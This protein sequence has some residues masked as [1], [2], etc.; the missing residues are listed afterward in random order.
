MS[1]DYEKR[2]ADW[3][4]QMRDTMLARRIVTMRGILD[5]ALAGRIA[6]EL[7]TLDASGDELITLY[8]DSSGGTL[9]AAF[10]VID[11]IDLLGVPIH[12]V[13]IG[14]AE[15]PAAA[16]VAAC[17]RRKV[18]PHATFRLCEPI[19][20]ATGHASDMKR[21]AEQQRD[22]LGKFVSLLNEITS[23][24]IEHI[25]ADVAAGRYLSAEEAVEYGLVDE[26]WSPKKRQADPENR[27]QFGF[28][29]PEKPHLRAY[30]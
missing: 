7:M 12:S 10:T 23:R 22:Q 5:E 30:E 14:R 20:Q 9:E 25:E 27:P 19:S 8:I 24:P 11:V 29:P 17:D 1:D 13:C 26:V 3:E 2:Q 4:L 16:V 6:M 18:A 15:G 28:R 21:F